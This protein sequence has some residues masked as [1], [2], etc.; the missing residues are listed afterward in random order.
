VNKAFIR[1]WSRL[2]PAGRFGL[3]AL[4]LWLLLL[5]VAIPLYFGS[6]GGSQAEEAAWGS[7][8]LVTLSDSVERFSPVALANAC[9]L[10]AS[11][12]FRCH[13]GKRAPSPTVDAATAPWHL[14][15]AKVNYSCAG[16]HQGNPRILKQEIAHKGLLADPRAEPAKACA[17]CHAT[18]DVDKLLSKYHQPHSNTGK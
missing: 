7:E 4:G 12:C 3:Q 6:G 1:I 18:T 9:G 5:A 11:S 8:A 2:G 15:H 17:G 10:G 14:D 16:C 13:N